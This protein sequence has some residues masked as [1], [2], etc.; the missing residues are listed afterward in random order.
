[1]DLL[2]TNSVITF[3]WLNQGHKTSV[4]DT[5]AA[6]QQCLIRKALAIKPAELNYVR[7][8]VR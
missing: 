4:L 6:R 3:D 5:P 2:E 1:M 7:I 8:D